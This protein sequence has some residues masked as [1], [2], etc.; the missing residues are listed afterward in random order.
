MENTTI[1]KVLHHLDQLEVP[2]EIVYH[3]PV[4][5]MEEMEQLGLD[6]K[7]LICKNLFLRDAK[8]KRHFLIVLAGEKHADIK[9][10]CTQLGTSRL[11]F[12]SEERLMDHLGVRKGAVTPLGVLNDREHSVEVVFDRDLVGKDRLGVHPNDNTATVFLSFDNLKRVVEHS[13]NTITFLT[14][15]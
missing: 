2:Y 8:G 4:Y 10:F 15:E 11:S 6:Q 5:T 12:G 13:G 1:E 3:D 7:G 9:A 14:I